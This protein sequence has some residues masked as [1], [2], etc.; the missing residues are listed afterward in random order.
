MPSKNLKLEDL[1]ELQELQPIPTSSSSSIAATSLSVAPQLSINPHS[2]V[3]PVSSPAASIHDAD[4][5]YIAQDHDATSD[6]LL[7]AIQLLEKEAHNDN[8][9]VEEEKVQGKPGRPSSEELRILDEGLSRVYDEFMALTNKLP[10]QRQPATILKLL[11]GRFKAAGANTWPW[12]LKYY[13]ANEDEE[14]KHLP[15]CDAFDCKLLPVSPSFLTR[16]IQ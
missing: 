1:G 4:L 11:V 2:Q 10:R 15:D 5:E 9:D 12:Y 7:D 3:G 16:I 14:L 6:D 13:K 8:E